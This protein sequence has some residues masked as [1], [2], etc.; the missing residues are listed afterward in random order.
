MAQ[1]QSPIGPWYDRWK[2]GGWAV[3]ALAIAVSTSITA[4]YFRS[5]PDWAGW[6]WFWL[7]Q[8]RPV[9]PS[10]TSFVGCN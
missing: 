7:R 10:S 8:W 2:R 1:L 9:A 6:L 5:G 4:T 3:G